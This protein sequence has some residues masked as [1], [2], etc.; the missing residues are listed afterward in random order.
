MGKAGMSDPTACAFSTLV[1]ETFVFLS[2]EV[3]TAQVAT[4]LTLMGFGAVVGQAP[5][6]DTSE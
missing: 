1:L 5:S 6:G 3:E 4:L 2:G